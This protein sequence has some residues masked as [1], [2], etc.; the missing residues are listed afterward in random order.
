MPKLDLNNYRNIN[1]T[2][3]I[4][5][6]FNYKQY[7]FH[8]KKLGNVNCTGY[9]RLLRLSDYWNN[10]WLLGGN[11]GNIVGCRISKDQGLTWSEPI[12]I[13]KYPNYI[14]SNIDLFEL[15]NHDL[16][17]AFRAFGYNS[18]NNRNIKYNR[19]IGS[20]ISH[21]GGY[22]WEKLGTIIDNFELACNL[23]KS[24]KDAQKACHME[25]RI[26]FFEPFIIDLNNK[27]I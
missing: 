13:S 11:F 19:K 26:G 2:Y 9:P 4:S 23:G 22:H 16:L 17:S 18:N 14:C 6:F 25:M 7:S 27:I 5:E 12:E 20:S 1:N 21:D 8:F 24:K 3:N 10:I 15:P